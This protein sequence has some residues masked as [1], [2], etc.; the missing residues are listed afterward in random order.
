[1]FTTTD[2]YAK[3]AI[4]LSF[5]LTNLTRGREEC[6]EANSTHYMDMQLKI[7]SKTSMVMILVNAAG[8]IPQFV[9]TFLLG[10]C[11]DQIG[12]KIAFILPPFGGCL[13]AVIYLIMSHLRLSYYYLIVGSFIEGIFGSFPLFFTGCIAYVAD[14]TEVKDRSLWLCVIDCTIGLS[15]VLTNIAAGYIITLLGFPC[16]FLTLT[17]TFVICLILAIVTIKEDCQ[18]HQCQS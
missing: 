17:I 12:R 1:M 6:L 4:S 13:K 10:P 5:N 14:L 15:I 9:I 11:S 18:K 8:V 16:M 3:L 7:Q 2:Q